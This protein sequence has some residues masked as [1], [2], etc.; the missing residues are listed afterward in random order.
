MSRL[1]DSGR[2]ADT[3]PLRKPEQCDF[4]SLKG[5]RNQF[6][7][8]VLTLQ[9]SSFGECKQVGVLVSWDVTGH[10]CI[11]KMHHTHVVQKELKL[12]NCSRGYLIAVHLREES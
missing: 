3:R 8:N 4:T 12:Y 10:F 9:M 11:L 2:W 5:K 1:N 7:N 6:I